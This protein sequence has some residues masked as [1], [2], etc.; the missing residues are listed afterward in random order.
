[1][2]AA[3]YVSPCFTL[4][5]RSSLSSQT[6]FFSWYGYAISLTSTVMSLLRSSSSSVVSVPCV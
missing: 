2:T 1:M 4:L 5:G 3:S 6:S